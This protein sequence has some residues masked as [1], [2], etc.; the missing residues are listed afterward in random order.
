MP[1]PTFGHQP[2]TRDEARSEYLRMLAKLDGVE[3]PGLLV[4]PDDPGTYA[5]TCLRCG[6]DEGLGANRMCAACNP[7]AP[8]WAHVLRWLPCVARRWL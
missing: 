2:M 8:W 4:Q 5:R 7:P 1:E 6:L 3:A